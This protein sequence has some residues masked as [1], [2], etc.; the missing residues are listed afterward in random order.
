MSVASIYSKRQ[1]RNSLVAGTPEDKMETVKPH[2]GVSEC[3]FIAC[4]RLNFLN[5]LCKLCLCPARFPINQYTHRHMIGSSTVNLAHLSSSQSP[6]TF[7]VSWL[8]QARL[9]NFFCSSRTRKKK[10]TLNWLWLA[11]HPSTFTHI[12]EADWMYKKLLPR[13]L[14]VDTAKYHIK[15]VD[16]LTLK[17]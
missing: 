17:Q 2:I 1:D 9:E 16:Y 5:G 15:Q 14:V 4:W 8:V 13:D 11:T 6:A 12:N 10:E 3:R 7:A